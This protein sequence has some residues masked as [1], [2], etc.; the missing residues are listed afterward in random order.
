MIRRSFPGPAAVLL[1]LS[2]LSGCEHA[3][4]LQSSENPC[5]ECDEPCACPEGACAPAPPAGW[6]GPVLLWAG[7]VTEAPLCPDRAINVVYEGHAGLHGTTKCPQCECGPPVCEMPGGLVTTTEHACPDA[8]DVLTAYDAPDGWDGSCTS[9]GTIPKGDFLSV[10]VSSTTVSPCEPITGSPVSAQ[11]S[12]AWEV[13]A[14]ACKPTA[15]VVGD[16]AAKGCT[17]TYE[18]PPPG[19]SQCVFK[20]GEPSQCPVGYPDRR[21]FFSRAEGG[22]GC[23]DCQCGPPEGSDC[24]VF[25]RLYSE[26]ACTHTFLGMGVGL[27]DSSCATGFSTDLAGMSA[28]FYTDI[29]GVCTPFG[30]EPSGEIAPADPSTFCCQLPTD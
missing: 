21:V 17:S 29:P 12:M 3:P 22:L 15:P 11:G 14:R 16:D 2:G 20:G 26:A 13:F 25:F 30:G 5:V 8:D 7:P 18:P 6:E 1:A 24:L 23:T 28:T 19:F 27:G 9:S 10:A 4:A